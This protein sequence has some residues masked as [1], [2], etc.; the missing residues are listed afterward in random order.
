MTVCALL[1]V[2][3]RNAHAWPLLEPELSWNISLKLALQRR[4]ATHEQA[5]A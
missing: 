4:Q 1:P 2:Q 5:L 3:R